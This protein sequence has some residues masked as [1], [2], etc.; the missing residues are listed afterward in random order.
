[1]NDDERQP[2]VVGIEKVLKQIH[3]NLEIESS[4]ST[5]LLELLI[6]YLSKFT[7]A[8]SH[9][10]EEREVSDDDFMKDAIGNC[11]PTTELRKHAINEADKAMNH[12]KA[13]DTANVS[14]TTKARLQFD[15]ES[16]EKFMKQIMSK[17]IDADEI[18]GNKSIHVGLISV[19]GA[20]TTE[21]L[22]AEILELSGNACKDDDA[23]QDDGEVDRHIKVSHIVAAIKA[24][25]ELI[26]MC[27]SY[28]KSVLS[29]NKVAG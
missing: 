8:L 5:F 9:L 29:K 17:Y 25:E 28:G 2:F 4:A 11:I 3:P 19:W 23:C 7:H 6:V 1:M 24:D 21:Y 13:C 18:Y 16:A 12:L 26:D 14:I 27:D 10:K 20:A 15:V 22:C